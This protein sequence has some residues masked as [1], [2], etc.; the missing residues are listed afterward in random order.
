MDDLNNNKIYKQFVIDSNIS[1][2]QKMEQRV[3]ESVHCLNIGGVKRKNPLNFD[4]YKYSVTDLYEGDPDGYD[5]GNYFTKQYHN[6][7]LSLGQ[8]GTVFDYLWYSNTH[9][10]VN[11]IMKSDDNR[12][13][14][15]VNRRGV[16]SFNDLTINGK[17]V[18]TSTWLKMSDT[19]RDNKVN[20]L[21][22]T[23]NC[24]RVF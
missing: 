3:K 23:L 19:E 17:K 6:M 8:F 13:I 10:G 24:N 22:I 11:F 2:R 9:R 5:L 1:E 18:A 16:S 12:F 21:N 14:W 15:Q 20:G 4:T 7:Q